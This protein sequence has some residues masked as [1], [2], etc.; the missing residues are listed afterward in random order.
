PPLAADITPPKALKS[1]TC[2]FPMTQP[3]SAEFVFAIA[4][5]GSVK[6]LR[7]YRASG[8]RTTVQLVQNCVAKFR[9][10]PATKDGQ[11]I[12][13]PWWVAVSARFD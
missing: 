4:T 3:G 10:A 12:E 8:D 1:H 11:P 5:D 2:A 6:D 7:I 13:V 9:Y